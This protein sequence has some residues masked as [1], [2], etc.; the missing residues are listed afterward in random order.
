VDQV[1]NLINVEVNR[2]LH[3]MVLDDIQKVDKALLDYFTHK[4]EKQEEIGV[5]V[6]KSVSEAVLLAT[7]SCYFKV[8][9]S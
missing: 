1:C 6:I 5:N 2:I 4:T 3:G 7:A 9:P 8:D